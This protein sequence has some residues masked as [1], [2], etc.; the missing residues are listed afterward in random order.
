MVLDGETFELKGNWENECEVPPS[1]YDFWY[2]ARHNV[3]VS[4]AGVVPKVAGRGFNPDDLKKGGDTRVAPMPGPSLG[5]PGL[6]P[7]WRPICARSAFAGLGLRM[8]RGCTGG[9]RVPAAPK[10]CISLS[11]PQI[12]HSPE[13]SPNP[14]F[15]L[16]SPQTPPFSLPIPTRSPPGRDPC[17][18]SPPTLFP[19][20]PQGSSG[21]A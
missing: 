3:L 9:G 11:S 19:R 10:S 1:G 8:G 16:S 17:P 20:V 21:A 7:P 18:C 4:S 14:A 2:Q 13:F 12:L 15:P 5:L 6:V